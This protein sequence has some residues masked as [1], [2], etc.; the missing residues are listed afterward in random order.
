MQRACPGVGRYRR[1]EHAE[2]GG[3]PGDRV[4]VEQVPGMDELTGEVT[5]G[6]LPQRQLKVEPGGADADVEQLGVQAVEA[7]SGSCSL[8]RSEH[9]W[10]TGSRVRSRGGARSSTSLLE[11]HVLMVSAASRGVP[12]LL[13]QLGERRSAVRSA[14]SGTELA[15]KP[16]RSSRSGWGRPNTGLPI[17][18]SRVPQYRA[19]SAANAERITM[20]IDAPASSA[21]T[22][23]RPATSAGKLMDAL[24]PGSS[25]PAAVPGQRVVAAPS[26]RLRAGRASDSIWRAMTCSPGQCR[27]RSAK[28]A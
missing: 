21:S 28:L 8:A 22:R 12:D 3:E 10:K 15:K 25:V 19:A 23:S 4:V 26:A 9:S 5:A 6:R 13:D 16:T 27:C 7:R 18:R 24:R 11:R 1:H 17:S 2:V 14:R 20:N